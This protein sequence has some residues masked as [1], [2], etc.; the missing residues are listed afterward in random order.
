MYVPL[1]LPPSN[2]DFRVFREVQILGN[3]T[4]ETAE[5]HHISQTRV[6]Q[7]VQ[8][9]KRWLADQLP[10]ESDEERAKEVRLARHLAAERMQSMYSETTTLWSQTHDPKHLRHSLRVA[11]A[12]AR[13]GIVAGRL[14]E[15]MAGE[16]EAVVS[17]Q[18]SVGGEREG[19]EKAES[20]KPKAEGREPEAESGKPKAEVD[21]GPPVGDFSANGDSREVRKRREAFLKELRLQMDGGYIL[22]PVPAADADEETIRDW[23]ALLT[24]K[25]CV[26]RGVI[27]E[28]TRETVDTPPVGEKA[29]SEVRFGPEQEV[30]LVQS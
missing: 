6:R 14:E 30:S 10:E 25:A 19:Q 11:S 9:V 26:A 3:S 28:A 24:E 21:S 23:L 2:R 7:I 5:R 12:M 18:W 22:P 16:E 4:W 20:G 1:R 15:M 13:L 29:V 27:T 17:R 8:H